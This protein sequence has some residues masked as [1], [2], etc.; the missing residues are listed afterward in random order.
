MGPEENKGKARDTLNERTVC[1]M[2]EGGCNE[3]VQTYYYISLPVKKS[4]SADEI[5]SPARDV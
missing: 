5:K 4:I 2:E 1:N 3:H